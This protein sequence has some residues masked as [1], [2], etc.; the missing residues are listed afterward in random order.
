M[1]KNKIFCTKCG[2]ENNINNAD[3]IKCHKTLNKKY[4]PLIE[5]MKSK[6]KGKFT[7]KVKNETFSIVINYI[8]SNL[9]GFILSVSILASVTCVIVNEVSNDNNKIQKVIEKPTIINEL[10]YSGEGLSAIEV[11]RKYVSSIDSNDF[12][13]VK[14]L[15][16][17]NFHKDVY[18]SIKE[19]SDENATYFYDT[20]ATNHELV[21]KNEVYFSY[22]QGS[23][24]IGESELVQNTK[25][26]GNYT[27]E[28]FYVSIMYCSYNSC[29]ENFKYG[30][31]YT[32]GIEMQLINIDGNYYVLG[33]KV[34][35]VMGEDEEIM[36]QALHRANG[37]T[38]KFSFYEALKEYDSCHDDI[39]CIH[40]HGFEDS[41]KRWELK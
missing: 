36:L 33:E 41:R 28:N 2:T 12:D 32:A 39:D 23:T 24:Y 27:T 8:K 38:T 35:M 19:Y 30:V 40:Q 4:H 5:Y 18:D 20:A 11:A 3:C 7:D 37:D 15:Q 10:K 9:Y 34:A 1:S 29:D 6:I 21:T 26:F 22:N 14:G 17:E 25:T 16:L 31:N 13:T